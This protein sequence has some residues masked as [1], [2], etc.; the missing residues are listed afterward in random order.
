[1]CMLLENLEVLEQWVYQIKALLKEPDFH[2]FE[3]LK[4]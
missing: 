1:M 4:N 2:I 3:D